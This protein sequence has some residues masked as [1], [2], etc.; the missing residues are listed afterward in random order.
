[1]TKDR[2]KTAGNERVSSDWE[3]QKVT[4][5]LREHLTLHGWQNK[6]Q[7]S[8]SYMPKIESL[9]INLSKKLENFI[10]FLGWGKCLSK[11]MSS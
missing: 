8:Y 9:K 1:M 5:K 3:K 2:P 11:L 6:F 4:Q 7:L 10:V